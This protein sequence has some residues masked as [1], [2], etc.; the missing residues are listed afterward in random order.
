VQIF[1]ISTVIIIN[2]HV[3]DM[4]Y[5]LI[6]DLVKCEYKLEDGVVPQNLYLYLIPKHEVNI[7]YYLLT[8][9]MEQSLS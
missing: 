4:T 7:T 2:A 1:I 8:Y 9:S 3:R 5:Q 6:K